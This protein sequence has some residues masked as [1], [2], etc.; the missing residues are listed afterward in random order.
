MRTFLNPQFTIEIKRL[1]C[2][3]GGIL[4]EYY[5]QRYRGTRAGCLKTGYNW[6]ES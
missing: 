5:D 6:G 4:V 3:C 1:K 2:R